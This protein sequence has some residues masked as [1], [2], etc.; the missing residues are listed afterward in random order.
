MASLELETIK[1]LSQFANL[2]AYYRFEDDALT[3][4][5]SGNSH[6]L[7]AISDPA[8]D[9]SGKFGG[10][11]ALDGNNAYSAT[12]HADFKPTGNFTIGKWIKTLKTGATQ[13]LFASFYCDS[14]STF[15]SGIQLRISTTNKAV[16]LSAKGGGTTLG[17]HYQIITGGTTVT[18]GALNFIVGTWDGSY[19]RIY[20][21]G[22]SDATAVAWANAPVYHASNAVR[23]GCINTADGNS[24]FFTGSLDDVFLLNGT[25]LTDPQIKEIYNGW[26]LNAAAGTFT[27]TG[28]ATT[29]TAAYNLIAGVG[30]FTLTGVKAELTK[31]ITLV[32]GLGEFALTGV[33][34]TLQ[35]E[36]TLVAGTGTFVLTGVNATLLKAITLVAEKGEFV[37][38]GVSAVLRQALHLSC[39]TGEFI[40]TGFDAIFKKTYTLVAETGSFILTGIDATLTRGY[41]L[42]AEAGSFV[43]TGISAT[44]SRSYHLIA[45]TGVFTITMKSVGFFFNGIATYWGKITKSS[46]PTYTTIEKP[47]SDIWTDINN[48]R[49]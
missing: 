26:I 38:T 30:S 27:L 21:N 7:T 17:T 47:D 10:A 23:V 5:S 4:D 9:S 33:N 12:D 13:S 8:E 44:L 14:P 29:L 6:T 34:A 32:C 31:A 19:L 22:A 11:V 49:E 28:V 18:D 16:L 48:L 39:E 2:K 20:V 46:A 41:T 15:F 35:K 42:V 37:L 40:L 43:L 45:E 3:T 36:I 25:A 24:Q 1:S